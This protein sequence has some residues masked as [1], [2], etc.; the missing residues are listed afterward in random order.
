[1]LTISASPSLLAQDPTLYLHSLIK[2]LLNSRA[3]SLLSVSKG[4]LEEG[5]DCDTAFVALSLLACL[6][7]CMKI[8][9]L[10][11]WGEVFGK[12]LKFTCVNCC[13]LLEAHKMSGFRH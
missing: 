2:L 1:M 9:I 13:F 11:I 4:T 12:E 8:I 7:A 10:L 5:S 6:K 3:I